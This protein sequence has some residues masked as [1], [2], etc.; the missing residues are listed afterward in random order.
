MQLLTV[1]T[2]MMKMETA[3]VANVK[4]VILK[5]A[6]AMA[7]AVLQAGLEMATAME[8]TSSMVAI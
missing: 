7:I 1:S 4:K 2:Y 5:T 3:A 6:Q 8:L